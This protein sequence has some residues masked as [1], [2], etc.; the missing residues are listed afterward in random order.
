M[1]VKGGDVRQWDEDVMVVSPNL[2]S[3]FAVKE[4]SGSMPMQSNF[5]GKEWIKI[6]LTILLP[7]FKGVVKEVITPWKQLSL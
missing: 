1:I 3:L 2:T 4:L 7:I 5:G 6:S